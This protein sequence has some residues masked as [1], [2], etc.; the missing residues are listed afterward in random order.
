MAQKLFSQDEL[1]LTK[2]ASE[3]I[4][5]YRFVK[6][7]TDTAEIDICDTAGE[8]ALGVTDADV[9]ISEDDLARVVYSG[10]TYVMAGATVAVDAPIQT[11]AAGKAI[12]ALTGDYVLGRA[13]TAGDAGDLISVLLNPNVVIKA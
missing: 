1:Y 6:T 9:D 5:A 7:G 4:A 2:V 10:V 3:D 13:L 12:T 11:D 8:L